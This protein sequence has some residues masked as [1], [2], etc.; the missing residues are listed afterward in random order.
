MCG[1][2]LHI[3]WRRYLPRR[4]LSGIIVKAGVIAPSSVPAARGRF[5]Q[6]GHGANDPGITHR[7]L[8]CDYRC[9][10]TTP[11]ERYWPTRQSVKWV[12]SQQLLG[13][14]SPLGAQGTAVLAGFYA[15]HHLLVKGALFLGVG[16]AGAT[17]T[18]HF[19]RVFVP[20]AILALS[21]AG[22]PFTSGALAKLATK[23]LFGDGVP[24]VFA[25]LSA[26]GSAL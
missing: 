19:T 18:R 9:D 25:A 4:M 16:I 15:L 3:L 26:A 7:I 14:G 17:G 24:A 6:L 11:D 8:R 12:S 13:R 2:L 10:A 20:M 1:C 23:P 21:L 5:A 22:L